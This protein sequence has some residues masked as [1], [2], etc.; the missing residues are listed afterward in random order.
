MNKPHN[1]TNDLRFLVF[2]LDDTL[3]PAGSG[4]FYEVGDLIHRYLHERMG[5]PEEEVAQVR[6]RYY[7]QYGTTLRGLQ[8]H[9][10]VDV[11][12]YLRFVH[13]VDVS[14]YLQPDLALDAALNSLPQ[15]KVLFTNA[16]AEYAARV[17]AVLGVERHF[18]RIVDIYAVDFHCKPSPKA[19]HTLLETLSARGP[20]CLLVEDN[21][22]N[23]RIGNELGMR[24]VLVRPEAID[25][26][27]AEWVVTHAAEVL[28]VVREIMG[29]PTLA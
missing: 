28:Q 26:D 23:L 17:M 29:E 24:T 14:H 3:Y 5:F 20:E 25:Q 27:G 1:T 13:D 16:T 19:Y 4:L 11:D 18:R 6:R 21:L 15:E 10:Q 8:V 2:D 12:D 7:E 9:H 22:R